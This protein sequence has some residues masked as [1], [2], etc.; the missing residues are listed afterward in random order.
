MNGKNGTAATRQTTREREKRR[1][2]RQLERQSPGSR[3]L[4]GLD[5]RKANCAPIQL[6]PCDRWHCATFS[7]VITT[8][9]WLGPCHI[10]FCAPL[11]PF[12]WL[13]K[14]MK[15]R[16]SNRKFIAAQNK[17]SNNKIESY[18]KLCNTHTHTHT[19]GCA[20]Y[21]LYLG[22]YFSSHCPCGKKGICFAVM[23]KCGNNPLKFPVEDHI[24]TQ[25]LRFGGGNGGLALDA[26][27]S[28]FLNTMT[29][30]IEQQAKWNRARGTLDRFIKHFTTILLYLRKCLY[31]QSDCSQPWIISLVFDKAYM[32][33]QHLTTNLTAA[34]PA[35]CMASEYLLSD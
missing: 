29:K 17:Y 2:R 10:G 18:R 33:C 35:H 22:L 21:I 31:G 30:G 20:I 14:R 23:G 32:L 9:Q 19:I 15:N 11:F 28:R 25:Y 24:D 5:W 34:T 13:I 4:P 27:L 3:R 12:G 8:V 1:A 26:V 6:A 16:V 7:A